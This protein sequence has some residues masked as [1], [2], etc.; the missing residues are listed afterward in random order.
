VQSLKVE[1]EKMQTSTD[2]MLAAVVPSADLIKLLQERADFMASIQF[3]KMTEHRG[4]ITESGES[5]IY[6]YHDFR[7]QQLAV[8]R[9]HLPDEAEARQPE[10]VSGLLLDALE[11][12]LAWCL[13]KVTVWDANPLVLQALDLLNNKHAV[14]VTHGQREQRSIPSLRWKG[15]GASKPVTLHCNEFY[16]WS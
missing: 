15:G 6:W 3:G 4:A 14:K 7:K 11:E 16:A 8:L 1:M 9:I 10:Q 13:P 5:W 12:A 2:Q